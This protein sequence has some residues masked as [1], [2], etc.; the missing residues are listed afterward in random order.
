MDAASYPPPILQYENN[1]EPRLPR[2]EARFSARLA[3]VFPPISN[4]SP[5]DFLE[6]PITVSRV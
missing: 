4:N 6:E 5:L 1:R 2:V 3:R